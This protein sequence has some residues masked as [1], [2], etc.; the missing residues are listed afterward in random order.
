MPTYGQELQ[1]NVRFLHTHRLLV[2][3]CD[4]YS[5]T[6]V[7]VYWYVCT[8]NVRGQRSAFELANKGM[9]LTPQVKPS[10]FFDLT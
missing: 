8:K 10:R 7:P 5:Y 9:Q 3:A 1:M 6:I 2:R 4:M